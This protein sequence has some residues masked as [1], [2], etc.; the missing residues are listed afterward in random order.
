MGQVRNRDEDEKSEVEFK[1][2]RVV[3]KLGALHFRTNTD[4]QQQ[5]GKI[6][7][8][9]KCQVRNGRGIFLITGSVRFGELTKTCS[10]YLSDWENIANIALREGRMECPLVLWRGQM[11]YNAI[12]I[13]D[14]TNGIVQCI[15]VKYSSKRHSWR[16]QSQNI[17]GEKGPHFDLYHKRLLTV[18]LLIGAMDQ[19]Q[20]A[21]CL[22]WTCTWLKKEKRKP[23][24]VPSKRQL[25]K[26]T[27]SLHKM[28]ISLSL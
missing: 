15:G 1:V 5:Y 16:M 3:R 11:D 12:M 9:K 21:Y 13:S 26:I 28:K 2:A 10:P 27:I 7:V 6:I 18:I 14:N 8:P 22:M 20:P 24:L 23:D 17:Q 19:L 25:K 4:I